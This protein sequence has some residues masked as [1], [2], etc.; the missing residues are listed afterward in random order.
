MPVKVFYT[1]EQSQAG[2]VYDPDFGK[3]IQ[4]DIPLLDGYDHT[5]VKNIS[6]RPGSGHYR[7][8]VNP[9]LISE[10]AEWRPDAILVFGWNLHSHLA[11]IRH[12][13]GKVPILFRG[14]STL[15]D[16]CPGFKKYAR[17]LF[18]RWVYRHVDFAL[19]TGTHNKEYFLRHGMRERQLYHAPHAID[20][21]RFSQ[22]EENYVASAGAWRE[23]LGIRP[24]ERVLLFAGKLEP[25]KN[26][27]FILQLAERIGNAGWK[28]VIVGNGVLESALKSEA[29]GNPGILFLNFQ[30]QQ[31]MPVVYRL[32]D[33][34]ILPSTG[35]GETW[36]LGANE[37]MACGRAVMLS[38][39]MG[40]AI[41]LV[42]DGKNGLIFDPTDVDAC[43]KFMTTTASNP[44]EL[45]RM[46]QFSKNIINEFSFVHITVTVENV[47]K[48]L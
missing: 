43:L 26:P 48:G 33:V 36:G 18:L 42:K 34:F 12:F 31:Q 23:K 47:L 38:D 16:E 5:F 17:R 6:S 14:D 4:W 24:E 30:N 22:P 39:R 7:G 37:A 41:D 15:L 1:W 2:A 29:A 28:F 44:A 3:T 45:D 40:G 46:K 32:G 13:H 21:Q 25:K 27:R 20:N 9:T 10:V 35:P 19:Y 11:C 8:V